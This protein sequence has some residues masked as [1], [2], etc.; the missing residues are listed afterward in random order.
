MVTLYFTKLF[1]DGML[2]GL[3]CAESMPFSSK[4][5]AFEWLAVARLGVR[6]PVGGSPYRVSAAEI[7]INGERV[8]LTV[9]PI[10]KLEENLEACRIGSLHEPNQVFAVWQ[11][12]ADSFK[13]ADAKAAQCNGVIVAAFQF[14]R[15]VAA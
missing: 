4:D 6:R 8:S 2:A 1:I 14:G 5:A 9:K 12:G 13:I 7:E 10:T 3:Q 15:P 11:V